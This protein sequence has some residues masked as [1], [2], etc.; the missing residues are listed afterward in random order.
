L[1]LYAQSVAG[2]LTGQAGETI[3]LEGFDGLETYTISNG[4][5]SEQGEFSLSYEEEAP[6]MGLLIAGEG[7]PFVLVLSGE[8]IRIEGE[9]LAAPQTLELISGDQN[10]LFEQ[11]ATEHPRREQTLSAWNYLN[12]IYESDS[13]FSVQ[14][15]PRKAIEGE[16]ARIRQEDQSFLDQLNPDSY[17]RFYLPLRKLVSSVRVVAQ[18]RMDEI[19][20]TIAGFRQ[21]DYTDA[22]LYRSGLLSDAL[23]S[24]IWLIENSGRALE[25]VFEELNESLDRL[26]TSLAG[27]PDRFN[28]VAEFVFDVLEERSLFTSSEHLA[29]NLLNNYESLLE[30]RFA[31]KLEKYRAMR[32]G[33]T[34]PDIVFTE[35]TVDPSGLNPS[36]LSD[37]N[38]EY[39]LV[40]FAASWCEACRQ[41]LP[42]LRSKYNSWR[43]EGV[44]VVMVSLDDTPEGFAQLG[45][46]SPFLGTT[47]Y[48][49]WDSPVAKDYHLHSIPT[50][51][52][53]D[54]NLEIILRPNSIRQTDAWVDWYLVK[55]NE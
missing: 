52:L 31:A 55:G 7:Q 46:A 47:D 4:V 26:I 9:S 44:E 32:I 41:M 16:I 28:E 18:Q 42:E 53:L 5:V 35:L 54:E 2:K 10:L 29:L 20:A 1:E 34:A 17:L 12:N 45:E 24:H 19:P 22:R 38:A 15:A 3:Q 11:Y 36:R 49:R 40:V 51:Y 6:G 30:E 23:E 27:K 48:G 37:L 8:D 33:N 21:I 25:E 13:L 50:Y 14:Q 43:E 39:M